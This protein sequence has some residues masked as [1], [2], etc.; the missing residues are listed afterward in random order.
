MNFVEN[1][2]QDLDP[3]TPLTYTRIIPSDEYDYE[4]L[5]HKQD[6]GHHKPKTSVDKGKH[7]INGDWHQEYH[8][9]RSQCERAMSEVQSL[10]RS[11][12]DT[13]RR[14]EQAMR[15]SESNRQR[16]IATLGNLQQSKEEIEHLH[17][18]IKKLESE[19]KIL[20]QEYRNLQ[21]EDK[22]EISDLRKQLRTVISEKGSTDGMAR[23][24]DETLQK[25]EL[26]KEDHDLQRK[27]YTEIFT[28]HNDLMSKF[29]MCK[30]ENTKL[31]KLNETLT[32]ERDSLKVDRNIL[33]Q[34]CTSAI[35]DLAK[36]TQQRDEMMKESNHLLAI[37]KQ[38]YESVVKD[39]DAARNEYNLVWAERD[40]VHKEINQLQD[41]LNEV[42]QKNQTME[43]E[44]KKAGEETEML[45]RELL[46]IIQQKEEADKEREEAQ[47]RYGDVKSKNDDLEN[48]RDDFR[49]DYVMVTQERDIARKE[50]HEAIKDR[51][52]ILRETY[53]RERT[54]KEQAEEID[55][56]S[57]ETEALKKIIE[58]LQHDLSGKFIQLDLRLQSNN[59]YRLLA[60]T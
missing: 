18:E 17:G 38:K 19:K 12:E 22:Q 36:V 57:K 55:Q 60:L 54:Q 56:V 37:Q 1:R 43:M 10:K 39:R 46:T 30:D 23:M 52:R 5:T 8:R 48:Q 20:E 3:S 21:D 53:E 2:S 25:Y 27:D 28:K 15:E 45:R 26:L 31:M 24:Y 14:C 29:G 47:K 51:D 7:G 41:K 49:K 33:K 11:Q 34:Q 4:L 58:K 6:D 44:K 50:R 32:R 9:L 16:Y 42:T 40:S 13:I 35:R 59:T